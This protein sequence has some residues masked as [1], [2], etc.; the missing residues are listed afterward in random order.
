[1]MPKNW[2]LPTDYKDCFYAKDE[3]IR[4]ALDGISNDMHK[5]IDKFFFQCLEKKAPFAYWILKHK[6]LQKPWI[7]KLLRLEMRQLPRGVDYSFVLEVYI[8][9]KLI[10]NTKI[11]HG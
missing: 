9:G 10:G 3:V 11:I 4:K 6:R 8:R 7:G 1:M 2:S 5:A